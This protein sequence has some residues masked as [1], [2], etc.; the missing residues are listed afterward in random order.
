MMTLFTK[1]PL[2]SSSCHYP[3]AFVRMTRTLH[4]HNTCRLHPPPPTLLSHSSLLI[5]LSVTPSFLL[6]PP[7]I[8]IFYCY[9]ANALSRYRYIKSRQPQSYDTDCFE[10]EKN[11]FAAGRAIKSWQPQNEGLTD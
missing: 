5:Y 11:G 2:P 8:R 6:L 9:E 10:C 1:S 7:S 3:D 4:Q